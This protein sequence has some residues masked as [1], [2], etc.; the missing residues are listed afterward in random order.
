LNLE[1]RPLKGIGRIEHT[2]A[3]P[4]HSRPPCRARGGGSVHIAAA[5]GAWI[6]DT[7]RRQ[8]QRAGAGAGACGARA[9]AATGPCGQR[10]IRHLLQCSAVGAR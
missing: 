8:H 5:G 9:A 3:A 2:A 7:G 10:R 4:H 1:N 6:I